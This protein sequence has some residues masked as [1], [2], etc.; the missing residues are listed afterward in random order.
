MA[1]TR[2]VWVAGAHGRLGQRIVALLLHR[3]HIVR[4]IVRT[5]GQAE[6]VRAIG[7]EA[8]IAD[9][10]GDIEWTFEGC[11]VAIFA[12]GARHRGELPAIDAGGAA[13]AAE[14]AAHAEL[15]RFVLC[16]VIGAQNPDHRDGGVRDFLMAK[17]D[18]EHRLVRLDVPWTILRFGRL[19][20][21][22]GTGRIATRVGERDSIT[23]NRDDAALT[24]V[25]A[26][27]RDHLVR[28]A[29][30][31][32][33]GDRDVAGALDSVEPRE[34]PPAPQPR[35]DRAASI[36]AAQSDNPPDAPDMIFDDVPPLDA[37]VEWQGD[38]P[39]PP[40]PVGNDDPAPEIP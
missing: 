7:A 9:L 12:A 1:P 13:K 36:G 22:E 15:S 5:E 8:R 3:G 29:I 26:L 27:E 16:S 24:V 32:I 4:A 25:E 6:A 35:P 11:E 2:V 33:D 20:E 31:V 39:V 17:H 40:E 10:R 38:G 30:P 21:A 23:L 18:A 14:A 37:D 34:L 19:T 28:E